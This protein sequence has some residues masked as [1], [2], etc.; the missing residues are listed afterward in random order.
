MAIDWKCIKT[1]PPKFDGRRALV[2]RPLAEE[3]NDEPIAVKR[4]YGGN[5]RCW[6]STVPEGQEPYN[7]TSGA[8]HVTHWADVEPPAS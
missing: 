8:C 1:E 4:L 3:S 6:K 2:F 5:H 7:P